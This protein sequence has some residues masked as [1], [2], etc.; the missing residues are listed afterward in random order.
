MRYPFTPP[1]TKPIKP[2]VTAPAIAPAPPVR[3]FPPPIVIPDIPPLIAPTSIFR[4]FVYLVFRL[5]YWTTKLQKNESFQ[6][7]KINFNS[8]IKINPE[9]V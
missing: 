3:G 8:G 1:F 4:W 2:P 6:K 5:V 7:S 9:T